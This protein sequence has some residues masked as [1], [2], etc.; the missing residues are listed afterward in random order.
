MS[1]PP[2]LDLQ[3]EWTHG[4]HPVTYDEL[5]LRPDE[6]ACAA[7]FLHRSAAFTMAAAA[8]DAILA[9]G[10]DPK[11]SPDEPDAYIRVAY[12]FTRLVRNPMRAAHTFA[13]LALGSHLTA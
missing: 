3:R 11:S 8:K 1:R 10:Q 6:A 13:R 9:A 7:H 5:A 12:Q 2:P 4:T